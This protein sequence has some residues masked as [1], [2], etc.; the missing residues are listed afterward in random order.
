MKF[1]RL[2]V[3]MCVC[4]LFFLHLVSSS[5]QANLCL[6][7]CVYVCGSI[8][9]IYERVYGSCMRVFLRFCEI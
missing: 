7:I 1:M 3:Y 9:N 8:Y 2:C 4:V 6:Y 5:V